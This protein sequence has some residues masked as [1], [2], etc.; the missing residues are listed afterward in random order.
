[1]SLPEIKSSKNAVSLKKR[2]QTASIKS[3]KF[4]SKC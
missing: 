3:L 4:F 1:M 2:V